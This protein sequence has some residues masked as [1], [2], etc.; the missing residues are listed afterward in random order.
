[1]RKARTLTLAAAVLFA[2]GACS[3]DDNGNEP[4]TNFV[5][6]LSGGDEVPANA[7]TATG[8]ATFTL[9]GDQLDYTVNVSGLENPV[10]AHIHLAAAGANGAVRLNLCGTGDPQPPCGTGDGVL[11][12]GTNGTT[13][14]D[15]PITFDDLI[16]AMRNGEAYVN[17]H[18]DDGAAPPN[19]GP[20]D[21][22]AG[23][24]RGQIEVP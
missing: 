2:G 8:D 12:T 19:S 4:A 13:V 7:S 21:L 9:D 11:A 5:A 1:M 16:E 14:G 3:D 18:T 23:E 24:I 20:G 10:V 22:I 17:V 6:N 15:P